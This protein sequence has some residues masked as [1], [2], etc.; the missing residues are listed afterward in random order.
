MLSAS[1]RSLFSGGKGTGRRIAT[2]PAVAA[3]SKLKPQANDR[4]HGFRLRTSPI[5]IHHRYRDSNKSISCTSLRDVS[6]LILMVAQQVDVFSAFAPQRRPCAI[7][8]LGNAWC[9]TDADCNVI[10]AEVNLSPGS[11][12]R[13]LRSRAG[14]AL[15]GSPGYAFEWWL[16]R[17]TACGMGSVR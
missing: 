6:S 3:T 12:R 15:A 4:Q 17:T 14:L 7:V 11:G 13:L 1:V 9:F 16:W 2:V 10:R 5:P 8:W